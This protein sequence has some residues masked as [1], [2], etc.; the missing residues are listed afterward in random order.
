MRIQAAPGAILHYLRSTNTLFARCL[1]WC[2]MLLPGP[3]A[4]GSVSRPTRATNSGNIMNFVVQ[5]FDFV[6]KM[7]DFVL[8]R[9]DFVL[10]MLDFAGGGTDYGEFTLYFNETLEAR[11]TGMNWVGDFREYGFNA[12]FVENY[13]GS[14][15]EQRRFIDQFVVSTER[16]GCLPGSWNIDP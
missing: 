3:L 11:R 13:E 9:F 8:K 12:V 15:Q 10:K 4:R 7:L 6:L 14:T 5:M 2:V 16:I 1:C